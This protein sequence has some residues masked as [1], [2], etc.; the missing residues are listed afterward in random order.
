MRSINI[1]NE[2]RNELTFEVDNGEQFLPTFIKEFGTKILSVSL[3]HP[4]LDDVFL[5]LTG[6]EIREGEVS[7]VFKAMVR[8]HGHRM[9][10]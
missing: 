6:H 4:S 10:R 5:K 9:R 8:Q 1:F 7:N 2:S 3:R